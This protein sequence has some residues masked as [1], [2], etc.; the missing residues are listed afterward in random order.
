[1]PAS[2]ARYDP[3]WSTGPISSTRTLAPCS[4]RVRAHVRALPIG[5]AVPG[6]RHDGHHLSP[7]VA[8]RPGD[9]G[10]SGGHAGEQRDSRERTRLPHTPTGLLFS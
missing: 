3:P 8:A 9:G 1:M 7:A 5:T 4:A 2:A 6:D 10:R